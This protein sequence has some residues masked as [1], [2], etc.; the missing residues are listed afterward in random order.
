[1]EIISSTIHFVYEHNSEKISFNKKNV[2]KF[3]ETIQR[4]CN[5]YIIYNFVKDPLRI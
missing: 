3:F 4:L 2:L 5:K 1:M